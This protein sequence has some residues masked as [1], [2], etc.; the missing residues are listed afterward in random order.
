EALRLQTGSFVKR[1]E[2][3]CVAAG[4]KML[5]GLESPIAGR[6]SWRVFCL[7][8]ERLGLRPSTKQSSAL[9][10]DDWRNLVSR[11]GGLGRAVQVQCRLW[12]AL[13][14]LD[15]RHQQ[16]ELGHVFTQ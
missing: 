16:Q 9:L 13:L 14:R 8:A 2:G 10:P 5:G 1:C 12:I 3:V 4:K 11:E 6:V 15:S 7:G